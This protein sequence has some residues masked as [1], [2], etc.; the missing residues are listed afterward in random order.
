MENNRTKNAGPLKRHSTLPV[1]MLTGIFAWSLPEAMSPR[2]GTFLL[3]YQR[4]KRTIFTIKPRVRGATRNPV[5][6]RSFEPAAAD[7]ENP[8]DKTNWPDS[9]L[10]DAV[11]SDPPDEAAF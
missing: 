1:P 4:G 5:K 11:R 6:T 9:R 10:I 2:E 7:A 8:V 3:G